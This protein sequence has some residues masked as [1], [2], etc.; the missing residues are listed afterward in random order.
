MTLLT[1]LFIALLIGSIASPITLLHSF[2]VAFD[3]FMQSLIWNAAI[4]VTISS[5]AGLEARKGN[6]LPAKLIG[7]L[8]FN[9]NHCEE[10]I[11]SDLER[12]NKAIKIL[13]GEK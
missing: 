1:W 4:G 2:A 10:A 9:K 13:S 11:Q 7:I 6:S 5:R 12:A 8:F 3:M